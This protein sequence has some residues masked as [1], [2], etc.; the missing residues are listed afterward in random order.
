MTSPLR[1][2]ATRSCASAP[3]HYRTVTA[4]VVAV[5]SAGL[6]SVNGRTD[7][8]VAHTVYCPGD[9]PAGT[10]PRPRMAAR[11]AGPEVDAD[12]HLRRVDRRARADGR[13]RQLHD[14]RPRALMLPPF[15]IDIVTRVGRPRASGAPTV[16]S[17]TDRLMNAGPIAMVLAD[18]TELFP[19][20]SSGVTTLVA[21]TRAMSR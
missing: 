9:K 16:T 2:S 10:R 6:E 18:A 19:S 3:P 5:L 15:R 7:V 8:I 14:T 4:P 12:R 1:H 20:L 13:E 21:S 17:L 11:L